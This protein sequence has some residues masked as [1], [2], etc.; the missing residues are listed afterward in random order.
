[1]PATAAGCL[2]R[3]WRRWQ[4]RRWRRRRSCTLVMHIFDIYLHY[5]KV[6]IELRRQG[7]QLSAPAAALSR[8]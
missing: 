8:G 4:A 5:L 7:R 2:A 6:H 3:C 1:M